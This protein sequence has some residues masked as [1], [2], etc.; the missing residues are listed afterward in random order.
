MVHPACPVLLRVALTGHP[1]FGALS[2]VASCCISSLLGHG[3]SR[4]K[5][6]WTCLLQLAEKAEPC[7]RELP[8]A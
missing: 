8:V 2:P 4:V 5:M 6:G 3:E 7:M 1:S